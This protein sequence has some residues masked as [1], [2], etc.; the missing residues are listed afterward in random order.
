MSV[1]IHTYI[2]MYVHTEIHNKMLASM[3]KFRGADKPSR[4]REIPKHVLEKYLN[5]Q[6]DDVDSP[7][8]L[9][10]VYDNTTL[11]I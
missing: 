4:A 5:Y 11:V 8:L 10:L 6:H 9:P 7:Q 2:H 3:A 1:Y